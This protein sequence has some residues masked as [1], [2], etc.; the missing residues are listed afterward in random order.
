MLRLSICIATFN[1][2]RLIGQTLASILP[3]LSDAIELLVVDGASTDDTQQVVLSCF[4]DRANCRYVRLPEKGGV[5]HDYSRSVELARGE[6]CWLMTDDD[7]A[8]PGAIVRILEKLR[9]APDLVVVNAEVAN[10]D[11]S[12]TLLPRKLPADVDRLF[13]PGSPDELLACAGDLLTFIGAVVIRRELWLQRDASRYFNSDFVHVGVIFQAPLS[14][15][16]HLIADPLVRI[17]YGNASWAE[18]TFETWMFKWPALIW[19]FDHLSES[20]RSAVCA[21][22]PWRD[23]RRLAIF[24]GRG[25]YTSG[26][27]ERWLKD[28]PLSTI[29]RL[30]CRALAAFP[31]RLFNRI[32][33]AYSRIRPLRATALFELRQSRFSASRRN[34]QGVGA[35]SSAMWARSLQTAE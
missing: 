2:G 19:S 15:H 12:E 34:L 21:R 22:E 32:L 4:E 1:R 35:R 33:L 20:A 29:R 7:L 3:Q 6:Y 23:L 18:R 24:K 16:A 26:S 27:Y 8:L 30:I 9:S 17:R 31:D 5:D 28:L 13:A 14:R 10:L 11:F 25:Y